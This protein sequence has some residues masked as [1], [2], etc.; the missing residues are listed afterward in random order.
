MKTKLCA[1][2]LAALLGGVLAPAEAGVLTYQGVTFTSNWT[3]NN[4][5]TLEID[6]A[7]HT[8]DWANAV[9]MTALGIDHIGTYSSVT[10]NARPAG[11]SGWLTS[12]D[13]LNGNG[14][15]AGTNGQAGSRLCFYGGDVK[16][17]D[18]LVFTFTFSGSGVLENDPHVKVQFVDSNDKKAGSLLSMDLL[19]SATGTTLGSDP[20][21]PVQSAGAPTTAVPEPR[22]LALVLGGL[23]MMGLMLRR[24]ARK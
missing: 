17:A 10:V 11:A 9:G 21:T 4:V 3:G 6:A 2:A 18:D 14:C 19:P 7:T 20:S 12:S 16:L 1:A 5:L 23:G 24:R 8:G 13:E 15:T 22:D